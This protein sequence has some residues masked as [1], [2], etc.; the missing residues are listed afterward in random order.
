MHH[1]GFDGIGALEPPLRLRQFVDEEMLGRGG[2]AVLVP[3]VREQPIVGLAILPGKNA[4]LPG[5]AMPGGVLCGGC[6][7]F[8]RAGTCGEMGVSAFCV[9]LRCRGHSVRV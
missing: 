5:E 9:D 7:A 2:R 6:F 8:G 1:L 3:V 4:E